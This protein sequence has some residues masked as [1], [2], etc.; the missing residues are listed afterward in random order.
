MLLEAGTLSE[1][2]GCSETLRDAQ[3]RSEMLRDALHIRTLPPA[4][5]CAPGE[6]PLV[7]ESSSSYF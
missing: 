1:D 5:L 2:G 4:A 7:L 3:R 6:P